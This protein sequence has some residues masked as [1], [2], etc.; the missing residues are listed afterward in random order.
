MPEVGQFWAIVNNHASAIFGVNAEWTNPYVER[1]IRMKDGTTSVLSTRIANNASHQAVYEHSSLS[2][3]LQ[4]IGRGRPIHGCKKDIYVF[5]NEN[6]TTNTE[7]FELFPYENY[8]EWPQADIRPRAPMISQ[9]TLDQVRFRGFVHWI[10][11]DLVKQLGLTKGQVKPKANKDRIREELIAA[12]ASKVERCVRYA[13]G[14]KIQ[15]TY[16]IFGDT[17]KLERALLEK[18]ELLVTE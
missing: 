12:G 1:A 7:V 17:K 14:N 8:F 4:A 5:S 16:F 3:T 9:V 18:N 11:G 13:N 6:L 10:E 15:R 2:E